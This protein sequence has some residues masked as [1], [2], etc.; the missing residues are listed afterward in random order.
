MAMENSHRR[1]LTERF[2]YVKCI[3]PLVFSTIRTRS[4]IRDIAAHK[5]NSQRSDSIAA[6]ES[7]H[8]AGLRRRRNLMTQYLEDA[9]DLADVLGVG[10]GELPLPM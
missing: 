3:M 9:P 4:D 10:R 7:Q 2:Y 6:L 8:F 1:T 5:P